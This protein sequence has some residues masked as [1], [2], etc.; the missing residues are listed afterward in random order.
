MS[1][2][3][4]SKISAI[5][6]S[7]CTTSLSV[8]FLAPFPQHRQRLC[9]LSSTCSN[10]S[11]LHETKDDFTALSV[12]EIIALLERTYPQRDT[13]DRNRSR[14]K[15]TRNYLYQYTSER[16]RPKRRSNRGPLT[17]SRIQSLVSF[18]NST[19]PLN[20]ELQ[21][22]ILQQTPRIL[23]QCHSIESRL[24][25]SVDFLQGLYGG[26]GQGG[27]QEA[28]SRNPDL[29]L[30]R[31]VGYQQRAR[32]EKDD[33]HPRLAEEYLSDLAVS[34]SSIAKLKITHP[35]LF[36]IDVQRM[37]SV[38]QYLSS[39]LE[40]L[41]SQHTKQVVKIVTNHPMLLQ[42]NVATNL[43]PTTYF[44]R[45]S[46]GLTKEELVT[47][48]RA[49]PG[50]L[51]LS[52]ERNLKPTIRLL[53][54]VLMHGQTDLKRGDASKT[55]LGKCVLKHPQILALSLSNLRSKREYFDLIDAEDEARSVKR[56][57]LA[58][59]ILRGAP[60]TYSLSLKENIIPKVEYLSRIWGNHAPGAASC[61]KKMK[62]ENITRGIGGSSLS[63]NLRECPQILTLSK[64]GNI[65]PTMS[66]YNMTGYV[67]LDSH[68]LPQSSMQR[69]QH[70]I[71][72]R[73][74]TTSLYNRLSPR[75]HFLLQ[76][77][78]KQQQLDQQGKAT[79]SNNA[80]SYSRKY[81]IPI[82]PGT[83]SSKITL[84]PLHL[85]AGASDGVFCRQMN[86][87]E[88]EYLAFKK[89]AV[90]RLKFNSQFVRWL[91]TGINIS[92]Q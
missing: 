92:A 8:A 83:P 84:P 77:Q 21:V 17:T 3:R 74:I 36:Q 90:P 46:M 60:S 70:F 49:T 67:D 9:S 55:L 76:I 64:E 78:E 81:I 58:A 59:T 31:G 57:S 48:I 18:L 39:L 30:L 80:T 42:L 22:R 27:F 38:V 68:A 28:I 11:S 51:G 25:P 45:S 20:E 16:T 75:W 32:S 43:E 37:K 35:A 2:R 6:I 91:K 13:D 15:K 41:D 72:S 1:K 47:V 53:G 29:L 87:S 71:R 66:F 44:L 34:S 19:F 54:D 33:T 5:S 89:E 7:L 52:V 82:Y 14:W 63:S 10:S 79:E 40:S 73:Y 85:L 61:S 50:V 4:I 69:A 23:G 12:R 65:I 26:M 24:V 62:M 86:L 88:T 56:N